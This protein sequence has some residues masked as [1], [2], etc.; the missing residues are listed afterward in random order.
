MDPIQ[1]K[2]SR[3]Q[4]FTGEVLKSPLD[5]R[6]YRALTL[7]NGMKA[8]CS[9]GRMPHRVSPEKGGL[10]NFEAF[11]VVKGSPKELQEQN[12]VALRASLRG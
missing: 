4:T 1:L 9:K 2:C 7:E 10:S 11:S 12:R 3:S 6:D 5:T 8:G